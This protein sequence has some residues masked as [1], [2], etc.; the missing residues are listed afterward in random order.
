MCADSA[1]PLLP[2]GHP[3]VVALCSDLCYD[4]QHLTY[5][6]DLLPRYSICLTYYFI[7]YLQN[8]SLYD[9][10]VISYKYQKDVSFPEKLST[11]CSPTIS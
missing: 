7:N 1:A 10:Q 11:S 5:L 9:A 2:L 8:I 4:Q 3:S 6:T